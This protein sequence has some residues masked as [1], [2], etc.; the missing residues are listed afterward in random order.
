MKWLGN[1]LNRI[2]AV[3]HFMANEVSSLQL[4]CNIVVHITEICFM[5][6]NTYN[7]AC[8]WPLFRS[9]CSSFLKR[10][11]KMS[12]YFVFQNALELRSCKYT[13]KLQVVFH[14]GMY[15]TLLRH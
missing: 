15:I 14:R 4:L 2:C 12:F 1:S 3:E 13:T 10:Y 9:F 6:N 7:G 5:Y 8:T 11:M